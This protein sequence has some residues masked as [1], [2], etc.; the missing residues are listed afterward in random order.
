[1]KRLLLLLSVLLLCAPACALELNETHG[2]TWVKWSWNVSSLGPDETLVARLD[3]A[4]VLVQ[5][6]TTLPPLVQS[7]TLSDAQPSERH[8]FVLSLLNSSSGS[9][10]VVDTATVT[11]TTAPAEGFSWL[12]FV[13]ALGL[14]GFGAL[15]P[16]RLLGVVFLFVGL[17]FG[18]Y[19]AVASMAN[20]AL[21]GMGLM[22]CVASG[23][24]LVQRGIGLW[25]TWNGFG[26]D[27]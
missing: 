27:E 14:V 24:V 12:L 20:T 22:V 13:V 25:N 2:A 15:L 10:M 3:G 17:L 7:Y 18:L 9:P 11:A 26:E 4:Q 23:I 8:E 16:N 21:S 1:M 6:A 19:V 5:N